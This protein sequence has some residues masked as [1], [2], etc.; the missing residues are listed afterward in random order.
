MALEP[1]P[2]SELLAAQ[3]GLTQPPSL[4]RLARSGIRVVHPG[5]CVLPA[6]PCRNIG[7]SLGA[8]CR[9]ELAPADDRSI[10]IVG[11]RRA[12]PYGRQAAERI[13]AELA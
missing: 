6:A 1:R 7:S 9:G 4:S 2:L 12:T 13:A 10:A 11:T 3:A 5:M 8:L